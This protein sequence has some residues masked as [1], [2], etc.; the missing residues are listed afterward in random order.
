ML[1]NLMLASTLVLSSCTSLQEHNKRYVFPRTKEMK[2]SIHKL[3]GGNYRTLAYAE[4][5]GDTC[6]VYLRRYPQCLTHE[7]RHCFEGNW[8]EGRNTDEEC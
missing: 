2:I 8:H 6:K 5:D 4:I 7:I 3:E 1:K